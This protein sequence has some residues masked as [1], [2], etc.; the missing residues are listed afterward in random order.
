F[1]AAPSRNVSQPGSIP[2]FPYL[3]TETFRNLLR[4]RDSSPDRAVY[5]FAWGRSLQLQAREA[6]AGANSRRLQA[7][8]PVFL[9]YE[10]FIYLL[11]DHF[12][13]WPWWITPAGEIRTETM[14]GEELDPLT[15][16]VATVHHVLVDLGSYRIA[17]RYLGLDSDS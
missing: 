9:L 3:S 1:H 8:R 16:M 15:A 4:F 13:R 14:E 11:R 12:H 10:D 17:S 2:T 7:R 6:G 5:R